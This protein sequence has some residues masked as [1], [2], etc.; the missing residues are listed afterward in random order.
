MS[1][2]K[3]LKVFKRELFNAIKEV[4]EAGVEDLLEKENE[5]LSDE[6]EGEEKKTRKK[7]DKKE[8]KP[9]KKKDNKEKKE[10]KPRKKKE[11]K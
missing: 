7:K 1:L 9:R 11:N 6:E 2:S 5:K 4:I 8:K 10:K 3:N